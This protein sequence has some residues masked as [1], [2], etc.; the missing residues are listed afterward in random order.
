METVWSIINKLQF[1]YNE[2]KQKYLG[3]EH[4]LNSTQYALEGV[5]QFFKDKEKEATQM[6]FT[7]IWIKR[8]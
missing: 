3:K 8:S 2:G 6:N 1:V 7:D 5:L 4:K